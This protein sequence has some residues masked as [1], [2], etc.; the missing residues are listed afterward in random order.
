MTSDEPTTSDAT[1]IR[2]VTGKGGVGKSSVAAA[3]AIEA[4]REGRRAL[5]VEL[6]E[7]H[8]LARH[9]ATELGG[10]PVGLAPASVGPQLAVA[11]VPFGAALEAFLAASVPVGALGRRL[12]RS[13]SLRR[14]FDAAPAVY[15]VLFLWRLHAL[16]ESGEFD[17]VVVDMDATGH[18]LM[19]L[20]LPEVFVRVAPAGPFR[21]M[22]DEFSALLTSSSRTTLDLVTLPDALP[23][24]ETLEL[25]AALAARPDAVT[26]GRVFVNRMPRLDLSPAQVQAVL[27]DE[28]VSS[29]NLPREDV[30]LAR[31]AI[32]RRRSAEAERQALL[33]ALSLPVITLPEVL[34]DERA[35]AEALTAFVSE[36]RAAAPALDKAAAEV[37]ELEPAEW[38][39]AAYSGA[40]GVPDEEL[41]ALL[42]RPLVLCLGAGGVGKTTVSAALAVR[43]ARMG[44]R[45]LV[46]TIDPARRL[47]DALGVELGNE[48]S[49]VRLPERY[50][51]ELWAAMLEPKA[52]FDELIA[53]VAD[54]PTWR[55]VRANAVYDA[56]SRTLARSHAYV[57]AERLH[58]V[59]ASGDYDLVVLDTPPSRNTLEILE[60]PS[61]LVR[62][63]DERVVQS[64]LDRGE[65]GGIA[66]LAQIGAGAALKLLGHLVGEEVVDALAEFFSALEGL[67]EGFQERAD[68][69][70]RRLRDPSTGYAIVLGG[71]RLDEDVA[72]SL[73]AELA[74]S[75]L[76]P[77]LWVAN[78][79]YFAEP[80]GGGPLRPPEGRSA[81]ETPLGERLRMLRGELFAMQ[82]ER[83]EAFRGL[84]DEFV[85][86]LGPAPKAVRRRLP[87]DPRHLH[88]I[89]GLAHLLD[90]AVP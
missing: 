79:A 82:R 1:E 40:D 2:L 72:R 4:S 46:L 21:R 3:L 22:L 54:E 90:A 43:A 36:A 59:L 48:A 10:G 17:L 37:S 78:R 16:V 9:F 41:D 76:A 42:A 53:R 5:L 49:R 64:F 13:D 30:V 67:R 47:A 45:V 56:F 73:F 31:R 87:D 77:A 51:G 7:G 68:E 20:S 66:R 88:E 58:D 71:D 44:R 34:G 35:R 25:H 29:Q 74:R 50:S 27:S 83:A 11:C 70:Q 80:D 8:T 32:A 14:F 19:M 86:P 89:A 84:V 12:A 61:R 65:V 55:R 15:E 85:G 60:A 52:S 33:D 28:N 81:V 18:A 24:S 63:L 57:A 23:V 75:G 6:G 39:G 69:V 26:L 38:M 62:F